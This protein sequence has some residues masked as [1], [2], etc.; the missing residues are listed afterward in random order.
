MFIAMMYS[1]QRNS[2]CCNG[3]SRFVRKYSLNIFTIIM[4]VVLR[5]IYGCGIDH[6]DF[7]LCDTMLA[8][9]YAAEFPCV[10]HM[11]ALYQTFCRNSFTIWSLHHSSFSS[12]RVVA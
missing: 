2:R 5:W 3:V 12:L 6:T 11:H 10:Y 9:I 1:W 7:Y 8:W 4:S